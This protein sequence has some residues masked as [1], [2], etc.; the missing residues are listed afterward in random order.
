VFSCKSA[1]F[2]LDGT[3]VRSNT[4]SYRSCRNESGW[5]WQSPDL[6]WDAFCQNCRT[7]LANVPP[8]AVK[9]VSMCGQMMS[10]LPID[11]KIQPICD[12]ITWDDKRAVEQVKALNGVLGSEDIHKI[13]GICLGYAFTLPKILWLKKHR[14]DFYARTYKFIQCKDYINY[15]L[16]GQLVTDET[17]AGF[18]QMYDLFGQCWSD[19]ILNSAGIDRE[20]LP[21]VVPTGTI[22]G[23]VTPQAS[24]QSGLSTSTLVVQGLGDGRAPSIGSGIHSPGEGCINLGSSSW[25]S[26]VTNQRNMDI[27][28]SITKAVY[29]QPGLYV[30]GGSILS[31]CLCATWYVNAF[32]PDDLHFHNGGLE[33]FLAS[34]LPNSPVGS[35]GLLFMPYLRGERAPWWNNYAKGGFVGLCDHHTKYDFCRSILE[36]VS[37]QLA[38][39]KNC[40]ERLE[41]FTSMR[42]VGSGCSPQWQQILS[43]VFEMNII[44]SDV[45][46]QVACVGAALVAGVAT[47][48]YRDYSE[49]SRFHHNQ[50]ITTPI[51]ENIEIYRELLPAFEDCYFALQDINQHL[52]QVGQKERNNQ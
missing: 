5:A 51:E 26:Q 50:L 11:Q 47:G 32:F 38:I 35:R 31:G 6:W 4:V 8:E 27:H 23:R 52:S 36:G 15:K 25:L 28:H 24:S 12:C 44:S 19:T 46:G 48:I 2:S 40:I 7:L 1:L 43:D 21:E 42:L 34:Q 45:T 17:D 18:T 30:N 14:P 33:S 13:T 49:S 22:L 3:L 29:P 10:C 41:P 39:I 16:T 9:A 37:F 20:K